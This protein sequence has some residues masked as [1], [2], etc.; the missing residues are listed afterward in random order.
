M[1]DSLRSG[2]SIEPPSLV[3]TAGLRLKEG[4]SPGDASAKL[5]KALS[6][7]VTASGRPASARGA[8]RSRP[9]SAMSRAETL[10]E[11]FVSTSPDEAAM[12][13]RATVSQR[14]KFSSDWI[15][16]PKQPLL[17]DRTA[18][19][20]R[21]EYKSLRDLYHTDGVMQP[22]KDAPTIYHARMHDMVSRR[23]EIE[24]MIDDRIMSWHLEG[25]EMQ[26]GALEAKKAGRLE[27]MAKSKQLRP[28][29][30]KGRQR[31]GGTGPA[32]SM[33]D[34]KGSHCISGRPT[35]TVATRGR[36]QRQLK[37][38]QQMLEEAFGSTGDG[39]LWSTYS[40]SR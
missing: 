17:G 20:P 22:P 12:S 35:A 39:N 31:S 27:L 14:A 33:S 26:R 34:A 32:G 4:D 36:P 6:R 23:M 37:T 38:S 24:N 19:L 10:P 21:F 13:S 15:G 40:T 25:R 8:A 1:T 16:K 7:T 11:A 3:G 5:D 9:P 18:C 28:P 29:S 30:A 2:V